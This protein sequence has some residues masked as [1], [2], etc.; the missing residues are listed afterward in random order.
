MPSS[1]RCSANRSPKRVRTFFPMAND[2]PRWTLEDLVDFEQALATSTGTPQT[3]RSAV[4]SASRGLEGA[5]ARRAGLRVWLAEMKE[6]A[7]G[8]K[9]SAALSVVGGGLSFV[10]FLGG[11]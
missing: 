3:V 1:S 5:A 2:S 10:T 4:A 8:R 9:F 7:A 6:T 11:I